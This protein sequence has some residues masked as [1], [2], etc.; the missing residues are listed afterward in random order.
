MNFRIKIQAKLT[1]FSVTIVLIYIRNNPTFVATMNNDNITYPQYRKY[2]NNKSF[3]K[4]IS[5]SLF[6]EIQVLGT[7]K[8]L[9]KFEAKILPDRNFI[10]DLTFDYKTNWLSSTLSE[11]EDLKK[12]L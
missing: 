2:S 1:I 4:I 12:E 8:T 9:H 11:F 7:K 5:P 6:E 10:H 3:F